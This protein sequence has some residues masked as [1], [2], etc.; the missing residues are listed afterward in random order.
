L[1]GI[2]G[3][4]PALGRIVTKSGEDMLIE[5]SVKNYLCF[6]EQVTLSMVASPARKTASDDE[7]EENTFSAEGF[8]ERLLK[9][10][11]VYGANGSGKS[12]LLKAMGFMRNFVISS[13][14]DR[15]AGEKTGVVPFKLSAVT[16]KEPSEF[17]IT[18]V[19]EG[20][21][22][23][24]GFA[25]DE[26]RVHSEW[27]FDTQKKESRLFERNDGDFYINKRFKE[28][29]GLKEKTRDNALFLS[30]AA[31]FNGEISKKIISWFYGLHVISGDHGVIY[32]TLKMME[33][34]YSDRI[35]S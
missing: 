20:K 22:Y 12:N 8:S 30:V 33:E 16:E 34:G 18:F 35:N 24:Y 7:L 2:A 21:K 31:Q 26:K 14:K 1:T 4:P 32:L 10:C 3:V 17:E 19:C 5:F 15:Q 29:K 27:L 28:G 25:L 6:K 9:S 13:S 23:R 11:V